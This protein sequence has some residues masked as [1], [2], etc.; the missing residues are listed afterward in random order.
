MVKKLQGTV[1]QESQFLHA[2][3]YAEEIR[4][5]DALKARV[6]L[7][8][9]WV[10]VRVWRYSPFGL[11]FVVSDK[12]LG[13]LGKGDELTI[14]ITLGKDTA[15][16][17]GLI[18]NE[19]YQEQGKILAGVRTF[20]PDRSPQTT[21][22]RRDFKRWTVSPDFVPTGVAPNPVRYNDFVHFRLDNISS[23]G[24]RII[25]SMRNKLIGK[26]QRLAA[27][28]SLPLVGSVQ[29]TLIIRHLDTTEIEGKEFLVLGTELV[30]ADNIL[31]AS[32]AEYLLNFAE[33]ITISSLKEDGFPIKASKWLDF[34]YVKSEREYKEVLQ[35]RFDAYKQANKLSIDKTVSEMADEF[36]AR[37]RILIV[38]HKGRIIG[39]LRAMFHDNEDPTEH[40]QYVDYPAQGFPKNTEIIEATRVCTDPAFR[41]S[42]I[43]YVLLAHLLL[44][45]VKSG[46]RYILGCAAGSLIDFYK[47]CGY[48]AVRDV[49]V[50]KSKSLNDVEHTLIIMDTH[51]VALG[52][53]ISIEAWNRLYSDV[54][55]YM[56]E[57]ELIHP[58][59]SDTMRLNFR[60]SISKLVD[61]FK[62]KFSTIF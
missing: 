17:T 61:R 12:R 5:G 25:T 32:L 41:G 52:R 7:D 44:T 22:D 11:E 21:E 26:E 38:K 19:M 6:K 35:L 16:Y 2:P 47:K 27:T 46:R 49:P 34:S 53:G 20:R 31:K 18:V 36:D 29:A 55:D 51:E 43:L 56:I 1:A 48:V 58:T 24:L 28:I 40:E 8:Q 50:F 37:A 10:E 14:E 33:G 42:D 57:Q 59:T 30:G 62:Y 9:A 15:V 13:S 3:F 45:A 39:S 60:R 4:E 54:V 23:G